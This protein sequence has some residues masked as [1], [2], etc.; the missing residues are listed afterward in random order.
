VVALGKMIY[1]VGGYDGQNQLSSVERYNTEANV[2]ESVA[3]MSEPRSALSV[4]ALDGKIYAMGR[5]FI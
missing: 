3:P 2:W 5:F 4:T 1:V